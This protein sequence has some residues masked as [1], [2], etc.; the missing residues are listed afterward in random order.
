MYTLL[1]LLPPLL[2]FPLLMYTFPPSM[3]QVHTLE[4]LQLLQKPLKRIRDGVDV[5]G[6]HEEDGIP[7]PVHVHHL[8]RSLAR[9]SDDDDGSRKKE[10]VAQ[11]LGRAAERIQCC[12]RGLLREIV[13]PSTMASPEVRT[14]R[15]LW[16]GPL[17]LESG[18]CQA[19]G[20]GRP[21]AVQIRFARSLNTRLN[22]ETALLRIAS[23]EARSRVDYQPLFCRRQG[24]REP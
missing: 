1:L 2:F 10:R 11:D 3:N 24:R 15:K 20:A 23:D 18:P 9:A 5:L 22:R 17:G 7:L 13:W 6:V 14:S 12:R 21:T 4:E 8:Q 16:N 19:R